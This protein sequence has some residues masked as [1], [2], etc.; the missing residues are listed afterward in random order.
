LPY[1]TQQT[2]TG[3]YISDKFSTKTLLYSGP[4]ALLKFSKSKLQYTVTR[5]Y[6][7]FDDLLSYVG[8][9]FSLLFVVFAF[10]LGP[11]N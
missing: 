8:G 9:L 5:D 2:L 3:Y 7:K 1:T 10:F 6:G 4:Y 11:Y